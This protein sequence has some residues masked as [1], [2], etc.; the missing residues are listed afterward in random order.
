MYI[1]VVQQI[2]LVLIFFAQK[3]TLSSNVYI[4]AL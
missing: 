1:H 4:V 2:V 3:G